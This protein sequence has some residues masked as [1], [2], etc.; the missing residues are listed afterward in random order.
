MTYLAISVGA[1]LGA[2]ARYL[3]G[4]W[5]AERIGTGFPYGTLVINVSGSFLIGIVLTVVGERALA[6]W[7]VRPM[8]A[9]GFLG[10]YTT[11]S[12]FSFETLALVESGSLV[13]AA[14]NVLGSV[15]AALLGVYLG[16]ALARIL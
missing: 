14:A 12:T 10:S 1:V 11:F 15:G 8:L 13:A 3:V 5:I 9:I 7:W 2:N 6:P 16:T 4:G